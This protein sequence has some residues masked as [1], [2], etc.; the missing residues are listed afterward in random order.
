MA[1][2]LERLC[3]ATVHGPS[4]GATAGANNLHGKGAGIP[5]HEPGMSLG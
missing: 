2:G 4:P 1:A 5:K 3:C